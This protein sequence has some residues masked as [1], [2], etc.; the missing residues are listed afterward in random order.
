MKT[1]ITKAAFEALVWGK[2]EYKLKDG[3][4][5]NY[6]LNIEDE[7]EF[8]KGLRSA[9]NHEVTNHNK[10]KGELSELK[11]AYEKASAELE[12]LKSIKDAKDSDAIKAIETK[13]V[14]ALKAL[15][16]TYESRLANLH[17]NAKRSALA[18][19]SNALA[20]QL[21][22]TSPDLLKLYVS[23]KL[24][25]AMKDD[26]PVVGQLDESGE[27]KP[28]DLE[29]FKKQLEKDPALSSIIQVSGAAGSGGAAANY[30]S[31]GISGLEKGTLIDSSTPIQTIMDLVDSKGA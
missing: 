24:Q 30:N 2:E 14:E 8:T 19:V 16:G 7:E 11:L 20:F 27:I 22:T 15:E 3:D 12:H 21:K 6:Y 1:K 10:T 9:K 26:S 5:E 17:N 23:N 4:S 13:S 25:V 28:V 29:D 31:S 18:D